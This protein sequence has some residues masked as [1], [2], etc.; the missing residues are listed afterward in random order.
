VTLNGASGWGSSFTAWKYR[1]QIT[2]NNTA[3]NLGATPDTLINFPVLVEL[4]SSNF[5]FSQAQSSGQDIR[6]TKSD[7]TTP[8]SYEIESWNSSSQ[9]A[10]IW[11]NVPEID[12]NTTT[13]SI[14]MYYG[15]TS[16]TD[17]QNKTGVWNT[18]YAAS[19]I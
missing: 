6:F 3:A 19:G 7:G 4:T 12:A 10:Y 18:G 14:Y 16:A 1:Q 17:A 5:N 2:F 13:D 8:L 15:D 9:I 11:V